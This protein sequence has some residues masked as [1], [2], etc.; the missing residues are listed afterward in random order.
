MVGWK[1]VVVVSIVKS[2]LTF[3]G[4]PSAGEQ[5]QKAWSAESIHSYCA[6]VKWSI[7]WVAYPDLGKGQVAE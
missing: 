2:M 4:K 6:T 7:E 3:S 5:R 1:V